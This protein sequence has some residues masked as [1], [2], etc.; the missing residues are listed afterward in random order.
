MNKKI[1]QET[2]E[3]SSKDE[4]IITGSK[5]SLYYDLQDLSLEMTKI[6]QLMNQYEQT[7]G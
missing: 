2:G 6:D 1:D 4:R 5:D 7:M 3:S